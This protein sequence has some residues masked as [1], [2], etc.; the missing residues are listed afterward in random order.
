MQP[1]QSKFKKKKRKKYGGPVWDTLEA[2]GA[3]LGVPTGPPP[4]IC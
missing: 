4:G 1:D 2:G 3:P